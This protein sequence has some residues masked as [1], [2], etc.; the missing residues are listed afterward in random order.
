M[1]PGR[2]PVGSRIPQP[3]ARNTYNDRGQLLTADGPT[4]TSS[5]TYDD[6]RMTHSQT[7]VGSADYVY[8]STGRLDWAVDS[9]TGNGVWYDYDAAGRPSPER[10]ATKPI[11]CE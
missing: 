4:G 2:Q 7:K 9:G 6:G 11:A 1:R 3:L 5:Y 10:Y 8:D